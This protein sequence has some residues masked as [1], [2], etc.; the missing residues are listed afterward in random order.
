MCLARVKHAYSNYTD[1]GML[2]GRDAVIHEVRA[3][4]T[5]MF[6]GNNVR[7]LRI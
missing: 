2:G 7:I 5:D 4:D 1:M 6:G 3:V